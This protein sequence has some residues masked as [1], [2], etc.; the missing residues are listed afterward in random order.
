MLFQKTMNW[1]VKGH[2]SQCKKPSF[3][4]QYTAYCNGIDFTM[5]YDSFSPWTLSAEIWDKGGC[6]LSQ[7]TEVS[8][9]IFSAFDTSVAISVPSTIILANLTGMIVPLFH[10]HIIRVE[11]LLIV[12]IPRRHTM[13]GVYA[14]AIALFGCDNTQPRHLVKQ[15]WNGLLVIA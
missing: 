15:P 9:F 10:T 13:N 12:R 14:C 3:E 4:S 7:Q 1:S 5:F 11:Y 6:P 2:V 8:D